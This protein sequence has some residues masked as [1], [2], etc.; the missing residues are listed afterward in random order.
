MNVLQPNKS[1][2]HYEGLTQVHPKYFDRVSL[3]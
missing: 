3:M 1:D 2:K